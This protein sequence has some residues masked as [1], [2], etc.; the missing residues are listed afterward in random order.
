MFWLENTLQ[1]LSLHSFSPFFLSKHFQTR[2][3]QKLWKKLSGVEMAPE[4]APE[5]AQ[6]Q[7]VVRF[8]CFFFVL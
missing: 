7:E 8:F 1:T 6:G 3:V 5:M 4:M 2:T